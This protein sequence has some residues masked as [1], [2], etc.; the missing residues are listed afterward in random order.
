MMPLF[1]TTFFMVFAVDLT[2]DTFTVTVALLFVSDMKSM[3]NANAI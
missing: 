2:V 1:F 3:Q